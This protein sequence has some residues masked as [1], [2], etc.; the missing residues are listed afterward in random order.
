MSYLVPNPK[1]KVKK[2]IYIYIY[3]YII[4]FDE[5]KD[6]LLTTTMREK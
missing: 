3:I 6:N 5:K 4:N 1:P 2:K